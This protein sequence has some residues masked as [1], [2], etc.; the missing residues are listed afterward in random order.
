MP[1]TGTVGV[2]H[3]IKLN[4]RY[5]MVKPGTYQQRVAPQFGARFTSGDP[6]YNNLSMWQHWA[7]KCFIGGMDAE[8]WADDAMYDKGYGVN[9]TEHEK[10]TLSRDLVRGSGGGWT[11][12]SADG[13][14]PLLT[15]FFIY[16]NILYSLTMAQTGNPSKLWKYT[17]S[18]QTWAQVTIPA[19][20]CARSVAT[21]DGKV[22]IGGL[23]TTG[24]AYLIYGSGALSSWTTRANPA[25]VTAGVYAMHAFQRKLYVAYGTQVWREKEDQTWDGNTVFYKADQNSDSNTISQFEVHLGFLYFISQNGHVHR[26]D[27]N[28]TFDIWSWDGQTFGVSIK[29]F[30]GR[31]FCITFEYTDT[32][33]TGYGVLYQ[34]SGSAMTELK[35]WGKI[36]ETNVIRN[37]VVYNRKLYYGASNL[38]GMADGFGV[39]CY[40]PLEDAHSIVASNRDGVTY[41]AGGAAKPNRAVD[42]VIFFQGRMFAIIRGFGAF[43]TTFSPHDNRRPTP[44]TGTARTFDITAAGG[45][46]AADNGGV[47]FSSTYD[48]GTP[49]LKKLWRKIVVDYFLPSSTCSIIPSY[50]L[51]NG[52]TWTNLAAINTTSGVTNQRARYEFFLNNKVSVSLKLKFT[53]RSTDQNSTPT[54]HGWVVSYIPIPEPN[55]LWTFTILLVEKIVL[56]D[57]TVETMDPEDEANLLKGMYRNKALVNFVDPFGRSWASSD[58]P[59]VMIHDMTLWHPDLTTQP[60]EGEVQVTLLAA[61]ETY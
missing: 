6:D 36:T 23:K 57:G 19:D 59:G 60:V 2:T 27:G 21:F 33:D 22:Y 58:Q 5:Y 43:T 56:M 46:E 4:G 24:G 55:W 14:P 53:L 44:T 26:T 51:D 15:R 16:N 17:P 29:S 41:P 45:G 47:F 42:D 3:H 7:Q 25:G 52:V 10:V 20:M 61:V 9:T 54:F 37:A 8:E 28:T 13:T 12:S 30:D 50:S 34:L 11:L 31:L 40:D 1:G 48:A 49:G 18:T 39:A 35:R 32:V 38:F